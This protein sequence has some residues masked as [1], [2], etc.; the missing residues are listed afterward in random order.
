MIKKITAKDLEYARKLRNKNTEYFFDDRKINRVTHEDWFEAM[1]RDPDMEF[2]IIWEDDKRVGTISA[3]ETMD[4]VEIGNIVI[5]KKHRRKGYFKKAI[6]EL[7][8]LYQG[9]SPFLEVIPSNKSAIKAYG[10]IGFKE[11]KRLLW[12]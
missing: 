7:L 5:E 2:F 1:Q 8:D 3:H 11:R 9:K 12:M 10:A 4:N 6:Y